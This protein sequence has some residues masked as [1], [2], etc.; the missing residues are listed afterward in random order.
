MPKGSRV[1]I[2]PFPSRLL[3]PSSTFCRPAWSSICLSEAVWEARYATEASRELRSRRQKVWAAPVKPAVE[4]DSQTAELAPP[5]LQRI[6]PDRTHARRTRQDANARSRCP[7]VFASAANPHSKRS[8]TLPASRRRS[9]TAQRSQASVAPHHHHTQASRTVRQR[10]N[11]ALAAMRQ[12]PL[13]GAHARGHVRTVRATATTYPRRR[14]VG[15]GALVSFVLDRR[16]LQARRHKDKEHSPPTARLDPSGPAL[17]RAPPHTLPLRCSHSRRHLRSRQRSSP[18][19]PPLRHCRPGT[20]R[21]F[22]RSS[23]SELTRKSGKADTASS[24]TS[25]IFSSSSAPEP[26]PSTSNTSLAGRPYI[27]ARRV[28]IVCR[29]REGMAGRSARTSFFSPA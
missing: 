22:L 7:K 16:R 13:S 3:P 15:R 9:R 18:R 20:I 1:R 2:P 24:S 8:R 12:P 5:R 29:S 26:G 19:H 27:V 6:M 4:A 11:L 23:L 21:T 10:A 14:F 28:P 17:P 25:H